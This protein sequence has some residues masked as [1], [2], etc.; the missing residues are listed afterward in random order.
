MGPS[1]VRVLFFCAVASPVSISLSAQQCPLP[2]SP[3]QHEANIFSPEQE[4][5]LGEVMAQHVEGEFAVVKDAE[6][7]RRLQ[8]LGE[9]LLSALPPDGI[10]YQFF[11]IDL[12]VANAWG[13]AGGR[14]YVSRKTVAFVRSEDELA[15][16]L[17]HEIGHIYTHQQAIDF[18]RW[19]KEELRVTQVSDREDI[20]NRYHQLLESRKIGGISA[21]REERKQLV[22]DQLALYALARAGY[23]VRAFADFL[24]RLTE[25]K[26]NTGGFWSDLFGTTTFESKRLRELLK[27]SAAMPAACIEQKQLASQEAFSKWQSDVIAY[28]ASAGK[29]QLQGVLLKRALEPPLQG[30]LSHLRFSP[31]GRYLLAQDDGGITVISREP[32]AP[33]F[34]IDAEDAFPA[35]FTAD[36]QS[37]LFH[38]SSLRV[39]SWSVA[40]RKRDWVHELVIPKRCLQSELSPGGRYLACYRADFALAIVDVTTGT[41]AFEKKDFVRPDFFSFL[42]YML[43]IAGSEEP[44]TRKWLNMGFSPDGRYLLAAGGVAVLSYDLNRAAEIKLPGSIANGLRQGF[45]FLA[46]D[47]IAI[48]THQG[49][50]SAVLGFPSGESVGTMTLGRQE[51]Q[52]ATDARYLL[53][54]PIKDH[55]V[56]VFDWAQN[57]LVLGNHREA[58]DVWEGIAAGEARDGT[59]TLSRMSPTEAKTIA[60][61]QLPVPPLAGLRLTQPSDDF[62][63]LA[64]SFSSRG[65]VFDLQNGKRLLT[66]RGFRGAYFADDG[67]IY[68][69]FPKYQETART[70]ARMNIKEA[71]VVAGPKLDEDFRGNQ[72]GAFL[73]VPKPKKQNQMWRDLTLE[74]Q[75]VRSGEA[76][77]SRLLTGQL[78]FNYPN[79]A[80]DTL[81]LQWRASSDAAKAAARE[82]PDLRR[83]F[84]SI[85]KKEDAYYLEVVELHSG[86]PLGRLLVDTKDAFDLRAVT[87]AGDFV[88]LN[89]SQ[90]RVLVYSLK[91]GEQT[92][93]VFGRTAQLSSNG[94]LSVSTEGG[95]VT[96]YD[97]ATMQKRGEY[98]FPAHPAFLQFS[99]DG[100]R[101]LALLKNQTV[102]VL[103]LKS[104]A[105]APSTTQTSAR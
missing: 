37:V 84:D 58:L 6:L 39:E 17:A 77:W 21:R 56:G 29:E 10:H 53:L 85:R 35:Q 28:S 86:K 55:P 72:S 50:K 42:F 1:L 100:N 23:E 33:M 80:A 38:T 98:V 63:L 69:D 81:V 20:F 59:V 78:P 66:V 67:V 104:A 19:F 9:R 49:E 71:N 32:P 93:K 73:V 61:V 48:I 75:E 52:A 46:A 22:A 12:P 60:S 40:Q 79:A 103:D 102:Y 24:D 65:A 83:R 45:A 18:S 5:Q 27:T 7:N 11:L 70:V 90:N 87:A 92:G 16:V 4:M 64:L 101:M 44:M 41:V 25:T 51:I 36:S 68:A 15:G 31:D 57:K 99:K 74:V 91:S 89:D 26:G 82:V 47:R 94:M 2:P 8:Q 34:H 97:A 3:F 105:S 62:N 43:S 76:L 54:R 13:M 88:A 95:E 14:I 30:E 96:L